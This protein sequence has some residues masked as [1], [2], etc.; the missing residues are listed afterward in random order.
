L[1]DN[2][3]PNYFQINVK[4]E[5]YNISII[6]IPKQISQTAQKIIWFRAASERVTRYYNPDDKENQLKNF[7]IVLDYT[8][9]GPL[10]DKAGFDFMQSFEKNELSNHTLVYDKD[11]IKVY[12]LGIK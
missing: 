2:F 4:P 8:M 1:I 9:A 6:G 11:N 12:K 3:S 7:Y 10:N 5:S